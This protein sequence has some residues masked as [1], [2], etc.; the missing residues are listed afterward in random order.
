VFHWQVTEASFRS[1]NWSKKRHF[2]LKRF[3]GRTDPKREIRGEQKLDLRED[4]PNP[5]CQIFLVH[6]TKAGKMYQMNTK[7][8]KWP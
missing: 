8:T 1:K 5:G 6:G 2:K 4:L 7:C 3:E